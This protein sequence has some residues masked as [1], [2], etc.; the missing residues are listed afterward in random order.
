MFRRLCVYG[1]CAVAALLASVSYS[2]LTSNSASCTVGSQGGHRYTTC[3]FLRWDVNY[4]SAAG[5]ITRVYGAGQRI[6]QAAIDALEFSAEGSPTTTL[7]G[8]VR[9][10]GQRDAN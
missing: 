10:Y 5:R 9:V 8:Q 4:I 7:T 3:Q 1:G 2:A 6:A